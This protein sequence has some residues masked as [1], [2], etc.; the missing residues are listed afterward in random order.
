[1]KCKEN[2]SEKKRSRYRGTTTSDLSSFSDGG[3]GESGGGSGERSRYP[4]A[5]GP[6]REAGDGVRV[7]KKKTNEVKLKNQKKL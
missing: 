3:G 5:A 1:M 2:I 7:L 4:R 6:G